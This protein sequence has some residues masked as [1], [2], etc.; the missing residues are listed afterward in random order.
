MRTGWLLAAPLVALLLFAGCDSAPAA[1]ANPGP[2]DSSSL[3]PYATHPR[4]WS[5]G[6]KTTSSKPMSGWAPPPAAGNGT[7]PPAMS[8]NSWGAMPPNGSA[9]SAPVQLSPAEQALDDHLSA[10]EGKLDEALKV[11]YDVS[12]AEDQRSRKLEARLDDLSARLAA[13]QTGGHPETPTGTPTGTP[14]PTP[15]QTPAEPTPAAS[16]KPV[17]GLPAPAWTAD[18]KKWIATYTARFEGSQPI[19]TAPEDV[20]LI[21]SKLPQTRFLSVNGGVLDLNDYTKQK[22]AVV[23][24]ILRGFAGSICLYCSSQTLALS[25]AA[26]EFAQRNAQIVLVYPGKADTVPMFLDAVNKLD[27][28]TKIPFPIGMDVEL[29][30]V[31]LFRIRGE[32]AKPTSIVIDATGIVRYAYVGQDPSDRPTVKQLLAEVD[33]LK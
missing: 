12:V 7:T 23:L 25:R 5:S 20:D 33:K 15:G 10:V 16:S 24:I 29:S 3:D 9:A 27:P 4:S 32:L 30:A 11:L 28:N 26:D 22:K 8:G 21:G 2:S 31:H 1:G 17:V 19:A 14:A 13:V 18:E 6:S